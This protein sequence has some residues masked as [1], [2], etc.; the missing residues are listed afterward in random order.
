LS[1]NVAFEKATGLPMSEVVGK[2]VTDVI[3]QVSHE[4]VLAKYAEAI[5]T[6]GRVTWTEISPYPTGT[7]HGHVAICPI[8]NDRGECTNIVGTVHDITAHVEAEAEREHIQARLYQAQRLQALGTLAGGIA[9]D[10]NNMLSVILSYSALTARELQHQEPLRTNIDEIER[11]AERASEMT[12]QLL[13]FSRQQVL[14]PR[15]LNLNAS[16]AGMQRMLE[17]LLGADVLLTVL[18]GPALWNVRTDPGQL[19]QIV[20]NLAVNARDA[21]PRGGKLTI[22][23]SNVV[24][25][26]E[27]ARERPDVI[28]GR[29]VLLAVTDDGI[30]MDTAT[31]ARIFEPFFTTKEK[32]HGTGLGL[33]TVFGIVKQ[34]GGNI[35]VYSEPGRGTTFKVYLPAVDAPSDEVTALPP[36]PALAQGRQTILLVEDESQVRAVAVAILRQHGYVVLSA[37]NAGEALLICEQHGAEIDLLLTDVVM[38]HMSGRQLAERLRPLRPQMK[39]LFISGYTDDAILQHGVLSSTAHYLE[40][41]I[42][43]T[44]LLR[45]VHEVLAS[46][47]AKA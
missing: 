26:G 6:R 39:V 22:E 4:M 29:Y 47:P 28:P 34:S 3:P 30:G 5:A 8:L 38:P 41:P 10:F 24:L 37:A 1:V 9:H 13:A 7:K 11:A 19:E 15:V 12:R 44:T 31:Q 20:M 23:T 42:T 43:P 33:A 35:W 16:L 25:N 21:M 2:L 45:K 14:S 18:A 36:P 46:A 32:G 27:Y 40:K 17:R